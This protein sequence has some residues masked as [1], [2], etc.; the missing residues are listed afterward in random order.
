M[1]GVAGSREVGPLESKRA[2]PVP[3]AGR[4]VPIYGGGPLRPSIVTVGALR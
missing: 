2:G 4:W 1:E 3:E